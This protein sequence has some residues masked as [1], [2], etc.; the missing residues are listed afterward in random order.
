MALQQRLVD[1][2]KEAMRTGDT[3][4]VSVIRLLR[5]AI[6]NK[7]IDK[8]KGQQLTDDEILQ[9]ISSAVKQRKE[10]IDQFEKGG[11]QDLVDK[12]KKE[13]AILQSFLPQQIS[14][15]E[16]RIKIKEAIAQS[17]ATDVKDMGKVMKIVVPQLVG[18]AEGSKISQMVRE[19][20]GQK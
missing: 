1:E 3:D 20:L 13:L 11:R 19:C 6:K 12:E 10:S 17:G 5:S 15:E 8:G 7:D 2:M 9:V 14:D 16:L 4:R 18:R